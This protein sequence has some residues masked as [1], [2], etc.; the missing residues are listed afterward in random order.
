MGHAQEIYLEGRLGRE[1]AGCAVANTEGSVQ[2]QPSESTGASQPHSLVIPWLQGRLTSLDWGKHSEWR[3]SLPPGP[4]A[5]DP[6]GL[7]RQQGVCVWKLTVPAPG[8]AFP[9]AIV[10]VAAKT[11]FISEPILGTRFFLKV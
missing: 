5:A 3:G 2:E 9:A 7:C 1:W 8:P 4:A 10:R 6:I 11:V